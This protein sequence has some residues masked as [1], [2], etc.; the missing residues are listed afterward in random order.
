MVFVISSVLVLTL[1]CASVVALVSIGRH[2][3]WISLN[4]SSQWQIAPSNSKGIL[5]LIPQ[6]GTGINIAMDPLGAGR[7]CL[8]S[9][10]T[11]AALAGLIVIDWE[12]EL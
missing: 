3:K 10:E 1:F 12:C 4:P 2:N 5:E 6:V 8:G 9:G 7:A 11:K